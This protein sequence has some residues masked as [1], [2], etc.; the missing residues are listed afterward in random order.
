MK[1]GRR[2]EKTVEQ[3]R[4]QRQRSTLAHCLAVIETSVEGGATAGYNEGKKK[5]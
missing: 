2:K 1:Q 5:E 4:W 3:N